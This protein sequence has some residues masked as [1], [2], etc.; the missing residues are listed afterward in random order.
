MS[1]DVR[2]GEVECCLFILAHRRN[3][4]E[5]ERGDSKKQ[6]REME[7]ERAVDTEGVRE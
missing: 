3:A 2:V 4:G 5:I 1:T 6:K 7:G